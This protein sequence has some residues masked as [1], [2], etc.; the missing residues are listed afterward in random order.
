MPAAGQRPVL[1]ML[2]PAYF[3]EAAEAECMLTREAG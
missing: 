2:L 1:T 3:A